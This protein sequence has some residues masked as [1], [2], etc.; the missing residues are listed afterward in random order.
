MDRNAS[1]PPRAAPS[2]RYRVVAWVRPIQ[3]AGRSVALPGRPC[4]SPGPQT[5]AVVMEPAHLARVPLSG[6]PDRLA[7]L[8]SG[9]AQM[10]R[11]VGVGWRADR[12]GRRSPMSNPRDPGSPSPPS[13]G[14]GPSGSPGL[15]GSA[16]HPGS[17]GATGSR[18]DLS[19][20]PGWSG[21]RHNLTEPAACAALLAAGCA[22]VIYLLGFA[23]AVTAAVTDVPGALL[24]GGGLLVTLSTLVGPGALLAPAAVA[25]VVGALQLVQAV[26][27]SS[28]YMVGVSEI[29]AAV[30]AVVELVAAVAV[31]LVEYRLLDLGGVARA[32]R[33]AGQRRGSGSARRR[34][35]LPWAEARSRRGDPSSTDA[36]S[37]PAGPSG[38]PAADSS[39][40]TVAGSGAWPSP[41]PPGSSGDEAP[42]AS[43]EPPTQRLSR[44]RYPD[45]PADPPAGRPA[46][47]PEPPPASPRPEPPPASPRAQEPDGP[48]DSDRGG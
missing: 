7:L 15:P 18:E 27:V 6:G 47:Q 48:R 34:P 36:P 31:L 29:V 1:A 14:P 20:R 9:R 46:P 22:L 4:E 12:S 24:L 32:L 26:V 42:R 17:P 35:R 21:Q 2:R 45:R 3:G 8:V 28:P 33:Q 16:G 43:V 13:S 39:G 38:W 19:T 44:P 37:S 30:L 41:E 25:S 5:P 11:R 23:G 10:R 40:A